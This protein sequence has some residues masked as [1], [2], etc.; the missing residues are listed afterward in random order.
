[1]VCAFKEDE[2]GKGFKAREEKARQI[3]ESKFGDLGG[4]RQNS[5]YKSCPWIVAEQAWG[6]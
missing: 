2:E 4:L 3:L 6:V 1:M 5:C